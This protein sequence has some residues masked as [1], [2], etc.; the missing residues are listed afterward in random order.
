LQQHAIRATHI[1]T[2]VRDL[3]R[4]LSQWP[5]TK[6]VV[7]PSRRETFSNIPL[8]VALWAREKGPVIVASTADGFIDQIE[9]GITGFLAEISSLE[10]ITQT[11]RQVLDLSPEAQATIRHRAHQRVVQTYNFAHNFPATLAWLWQGQSRRT[12]EDAHRS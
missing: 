3:P 7:V 1:K 8:E 2:F 12:S 11:V 9:P 6:A 10:Q 5:R 4:A